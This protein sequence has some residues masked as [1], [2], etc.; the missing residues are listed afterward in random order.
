MEKKN[1][2]MM[3]EFH[4]VKRID[5]SRLRRHIEPAKLRNLYRTVALGGVMAAF[6]M[7]YIYQHFRCIDLSFQLEDLKSRQTQSTALNSE[8]RLEIE[9]LRD[10]RRIDVIARRQLGLTQP[11][12]TQVQE[13]D[14]PSGAEVAAARYVRSNHE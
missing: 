10:P 6:F 5:N 7:L 13:Y 9:G 3:V 12:P 1:K 2:A 4:T 8:L 14:A 11:M